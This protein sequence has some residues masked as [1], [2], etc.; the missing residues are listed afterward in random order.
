MSNTIRVISQKGKKTEEVE[1]HTKG[2]GVA[3]LHTNMPYAE[4]THAEGEPQRP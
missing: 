1:E 3:K 4:S 2:G